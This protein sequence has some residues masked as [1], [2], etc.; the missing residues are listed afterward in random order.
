MCGIRAD[1]N[2]LI[3]ARV[4]G[5]GILSTLDNGPFVTLVT[6]KYN[7]LR[8]KNSCHGRKSGEYTADKVGC[9]L[10]MKLSCHYEST[11]VV[12]RHCN[13]DGSLQGGDERI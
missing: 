3:L 9:F 7:E 12:P 13:N 10:R 2:R 8:D 6:D 5:S 1:S 11:N 4:Q